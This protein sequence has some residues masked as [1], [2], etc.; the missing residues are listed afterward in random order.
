LRLAVTFDDSGQPRIEY[1]FPLG[2]VADPERVETSG[3]TMD[4]TDGHYRTL[5]FSR[6][7]VEAHEK[8]RIELQ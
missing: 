6:D 2:N 8:D 1:N 5:Y 4:W 7:E 3:F